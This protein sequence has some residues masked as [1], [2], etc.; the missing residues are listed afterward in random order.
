MSQHPFDLGLL[1]WPS[2]MIFVIVFGASLAVLRRPGTA[3]G[4]AAI[5]TAI[6]LVYFGWF[7]DGTFTYLDDW[8]YFERGAYIHDLGLSPSDL[9]DS[10]PLLLAIGEGDHFL[11]YVYNAFTFSLFGTH[12]FAPVAMNVLVTSLIAWLGVRLAVSERL[13]SLRQAS[14][15]F[16]FLIL[17]PDITAWSSLVNG[18]DTLVLLLHVLL[19][20]SVSGFLR[21]RRLAPLLLAGAS[22]TALLFLRFYVPVMFAIALSAG[23]LS[24]VR[25]AARWRAMLVASMALIGLLLVIGDSLSFAMESVRAQFVNPFLGLA[26]FLL[27]PIPFNTDA[28]FAFLDLPAVLHWLMLPALM[29]GAWKIQ[30]MSTPFSRVLVF[31]VVV[32]AALYAVYGELQGPR[33]RLQLDYAFALFQFTGFG[34][35]A[36][37]IAIKA[38]QSDSSVAISLRASEA[39]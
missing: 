19:L 39:P 12:Y 27:T 36:R 33:H 26:R 2:L 35:L 32:F 14:L 38:S 20:T 7:F 24:T 30:R 1:V 6:F 9:L 21:G 5:K 16:I 29:L 22:V 10:L 37:L 18:K 25:G 17:H 28:A 4:I 15:L 34:V 31:Y 3:T 23:A 8:T 13:C 11:Y